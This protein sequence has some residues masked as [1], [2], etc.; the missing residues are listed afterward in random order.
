MANSYG[1]KLYLIGYQCVIIAFLLTCIILVMML[2][3]FLFHTFSICRSN[4]HSVFTTWYI[5]ITFTS[6]LI[7]R[8]KRLHAWRFLWPFCSKTCQCN[9]RY[10][11]MFFAIKWCPMQT[12]FI[13]KCSFAEYIYAAIMWI[14]F[15]IVIFNFKM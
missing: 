8:A 15:I 9:V 12:Y 6:I 7:F 14:T 5:H 1:H 3:I 13:L 4:N 2:R 10:I 11:Y